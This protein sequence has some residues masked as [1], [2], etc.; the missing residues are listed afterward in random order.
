[1]ARRLYRFAGVLMVCRRSR[2]GCGC[3]WPTAS[4]GLA[5]RQAG[6]RRRRAR[7][8]H[9]CGRLLRGSSRA[10]RRSDK[11]LPRLQRVVRAAPVLPRSWSWLSS[12]RCD[13]GS[14]SWRPVPHPLTGTGL[15]SGSRG[16]GRVMARP[17][18]L[19]GRLAL[20]WA[21]RSPTPACTRSPVGTT[22]QGLWSLD[23]LNLPWPRW[24]DRFDVVANLLGYLPLGALVRRRG[25][26]AGAGAERRG[27]S[28]WCCWP[29]CRWCSIDRTGPA[30]ARAVGTST[31]RS[32]RL[33][34]NAGRAL[35]ALADG[36]HGALAPSART[37]SRARAPPR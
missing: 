11:W 34:R 4:L 37:G 10:N 27:C 24:W 20:A 31:S 3:G 35:G 25:C 13:G 17:G 18:E 36:A 16:P 14:R 2:S 19:G 21:V 32:T 33:V 1:M 22:R 15:R 23:L 26:A 12:S 29:P 9:V 6:A 28:P 30:A 7:H 8:H 5:A